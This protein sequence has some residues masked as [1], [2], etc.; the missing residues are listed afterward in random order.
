MVRRPEGVCGECQSV[1][2]DSQCGVC[3][4]KTFSVQSVVWELT[5]CIL[6]TAIILV[7]V[8]TL[9]VLCVA[10]RY[11]DIQCAGSSLETVRVCM[12]TVIEQ[13]G[14]LQCVMCSA[15][16]NFA[17]GGMKTLITQCVETVIM[18][19]GDC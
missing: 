9:S 8:E 14:L 11:G 4:V 13:C 18:W 15:G 7:T 1:C 19:C 2:G 10:W 5:V 12:D 17:V 6:K 3:I 16:E